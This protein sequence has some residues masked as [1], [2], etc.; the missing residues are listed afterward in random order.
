M[1]DFAG[2]STNAS[3]QELL[4]LRE[5]GL[6]CPLASLPLVRGS[7]LNAALS[8]FPARGYFT[9]QPGRAAHTASESRR[10]EADKSQ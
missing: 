7:G 10:D 3:G 1:L 6:G 2:M 4:L 8:S 5:A 9:V